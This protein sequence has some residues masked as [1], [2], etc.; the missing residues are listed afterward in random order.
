MASDPATVQ[1]LAATDLFSS[2]SKRSLDRVAA[3][4]RT[5]HHAAGKQITAEGDSGVGFHLIVDGTA[6][7]TVGGASRAEIGPGRYFGEISLIDGGPRSAS[8]TAL[9]DVTTVS[10]VTWDFNPILESE[11]EIA[12]ALLLVMCKRLRA[13]ERG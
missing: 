3:S 6:S 1:A 2:L 4:A 11:P 9:T 7:V 12:R 13:A 8:V 5:V 10:L